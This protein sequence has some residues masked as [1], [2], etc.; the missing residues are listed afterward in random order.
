[1]SMIIYL[2]QLSYF[3]VILALLHQ[4]TH[5]LIILICFEGIMLTLVILIPAVLYG[6]NIINMPVLALLI[7]TLGACEASLGLRLL[8]N[9]SRTYGSDI[10]KLIHLNKC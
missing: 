3:I 7:L 2:L 9:M 10:V 6:S 1:M 4:H 5:F 8:V